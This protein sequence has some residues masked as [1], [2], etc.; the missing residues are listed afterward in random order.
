MGENKKRV[1]FA[2]EGTQVLAGRE[3]DI[4]PVAVRAPAL[5][6]LWVLLAVAAICLTVLVIV[7]GGL[8]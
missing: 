3:R 5:R 7:I 6:L 2:D 4:L 1:L 8:L